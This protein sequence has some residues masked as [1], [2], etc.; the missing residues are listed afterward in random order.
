MLC[1]N[2]KTEKGGKNPFL[3]LPFDNIAY[4]KDRQ[5]K[6]RRYCYDIKRV[7]E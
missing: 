3:N 7:K 5:N 4:Q 6:G 2:K 1:A